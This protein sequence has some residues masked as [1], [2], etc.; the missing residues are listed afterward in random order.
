MLGV[1]RRTVQH[2]AKTGRLPS[3]Q[4]PGPNGAYLFD[5]ADIASLAAGPAAPHRQAGVMTAA[6]QVAARRASEGQSV[7]A[8][9]ALGIVRARL[10]MGTADD[11]APELLAMIDAVYEP[12]ANQQVPGG[13]GQSG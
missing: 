1:P 12:A 3:D 2:W 11:T 4:L 5:P 8:H 13:G 9:M 10:E 6:D 7:A